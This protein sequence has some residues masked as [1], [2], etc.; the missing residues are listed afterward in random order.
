MPYII[1]SQ[2]F[3]HS[4]KDKLF[5]N[6]AKSIPKWFARDRIKNVPHSIP[7]GAVSVECGFHWCSLV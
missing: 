4:I 2:A 3:F 1:V 6:T 5:I 7:V